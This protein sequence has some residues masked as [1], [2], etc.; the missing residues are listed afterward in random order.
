MSANSLYPSKDTL[1]PKPAQ[2]ATQ[3][4]ALTAQGPPIRFSH[5]L[6]YRVLRICI[7]S[8]HRRA[9]LAS[10]RLS[11]GPLLRRAAR[12]YRI[13]LTQT[14]RHLASYCSKCRCKIKHAMKSNALQIVEHDVALETAD[15]LFSPGQKT[16]A[17]LVLW[18]THDVC[19][20]SRNKISAVER[21]SP[22][23]PNSKRSSLCDDALPT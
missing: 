5:H 6:A 9:N 13:D 1:P 12:P 3:G 10:N 14:R 20:S 23:L 22:A 11:I 7:V 19:N 2:S 15:R 4:L 16:V 8:S 21:S 17:R 18:C